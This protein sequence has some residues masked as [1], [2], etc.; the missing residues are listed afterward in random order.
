MRKIVNTRLRNIENFR[1]KF[2]SNRECSI[3]RLFAQNDAP[4]KLR[5]RNDVTIVAFSATQ[6]LLETR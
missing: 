3:E 1:V 4:A 6:C 5:A 2:R